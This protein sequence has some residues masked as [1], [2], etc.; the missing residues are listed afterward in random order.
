[1]LKAPSA[2]ALK[3]DSTLRPKRMSFVCC[4]VSPVDQVSKTFKEVM[5]QLSPSAIVTLRIKKGSGL[6][7]NRV[8]VQ[9]TKLIWLL[10]DVVR[11][12]N[13]D[14]ALLFDDQSTFKE[15]DNCDKEKC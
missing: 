11:F 9:Q 8:F 1:M 14:D 3:D 4:I 13:N 5:V 10:S 15:V 6:F 7:S 12:S 2:L